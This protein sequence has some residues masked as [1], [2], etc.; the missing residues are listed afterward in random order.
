VG[1]AIVSSPPHVSEPVA[2]TGRALTVDSQNHPRLALARDIWAPIGTFVVSCDDANCLTEANWQSTQV[3]ADVAQA[4]ALVALGNG[5]RLI[6]NPRGVLNWQECTAGCT[7][8]TA[9]AGTDTFYAPTR[10]ISL[11]LTAQGQPRVAFN[12]GG[13]GEAQFQ[14]FTFYGW[15]DGAC[16]TVGNWSN[17]KLPLQQGDGEAGLSLLVDNTGAA[18]IAYSTATGVGVTAC[19]TG[20][21]AVGA[22]WVAAEI[23]TN[24]NV[25]PSPPLPACSTG[26]TPKAFWYP[27][28]Q[29]Q[30][31]MDPLGNLGLIDETY[32]LQQCGSNTPREGVRLPR[33]HQL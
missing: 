21:A 33:Y 9:W 18:A 10:A 15:C 19:S 16:T 29:V 1:V 12:L 11:A 22:N 2:L 6:S 32:A 17:A 31:A 26:V 20:C 28:R 4:G 13:M 27:G 25:T 14:H 3:T 8:P 23:E 30:A 24:T 5:L 7:S